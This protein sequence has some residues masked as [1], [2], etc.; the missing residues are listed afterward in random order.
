MPI[1]TQYT[2]IDIDIDVSDFV[3]ECSEREIKHLVKI[4]QKEGYLTPD[5]IINNSDNILD[6]EYKTALNKLYNKRIYLT[7]DE[8]QFI[9]QLANKI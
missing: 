6:I 1:I 9:K 8:E 3:A 5:N 7:L 2:D 4:L